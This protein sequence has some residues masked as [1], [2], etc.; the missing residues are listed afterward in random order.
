[1]SRLRDQSGLTMIE[2]AV[3]AA[4]SLVVLGIAMT[5]MITM[6]R[7]GTL[8][9]RHADTTQQA[10]QTSDRLAR[11]LRNLAS[12]GIEIAASTSA[13]PKSVDR[14]DPF[15]LVFKDVDEG[16]LTSPTLNPANVRRVRYCLQ[17]AGAV[18]GGAGNASSARGVLWM[19]TQRNAPGQ[20]LA[21]APPADTACPGA[22]WDDRR[23]VADS[24]TNANATPVRPL[25]RYSASTGEVTGTDDASREQIIRVATDL[26]VDP[27]TA[28]KPE[29]AHLVTS[30]VLRN[31]NRV[32]TA[33]FTAIAVGSC[34]VQLNGS[35]SDDP[36]NKRLTYQW[37]MD[38]ALLSEDL[39]NR[40]VVQKAVGSG[41][42][43]FK[44]VVIDPAEL[45]SAPATQSITAC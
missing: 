9:E 28:Q 12:P 33:S 4:I 41:P 43:T 26:Y 7:G 32:P 29:E 35:G 5:M 27:D 36:E 22:G 1:M 8:T 21:P 13:Q 19:Q 39:Q 15:D 2:L 20:A 30:V 23:I 44:L 34:T 18:P 10:R 42:H 24:I 45:Q 11:Q 40:V 25:F 31:Q 16:P 37:W 3:A 38:G 6:W 14:N 17:T